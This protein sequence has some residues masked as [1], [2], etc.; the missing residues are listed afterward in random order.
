MF[1]SVSL[2]VIQPNIPLLGQECLPIVLH[3]LFFQVSKFAV[4]THEES[5]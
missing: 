1:V 5:S 3:Q 4:R 2:L